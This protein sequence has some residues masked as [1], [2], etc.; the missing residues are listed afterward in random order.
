MKKILLSILGFL[1]ITTINAVEATITFSEKGYANAQEVA[2]V[3]VD[4]NVTLTFDK[5]TNSNTPKYYNTGA[6]LRIYGGGTMT[7]SGV[8]AVIN[9]V[10]MTTGTGNT[11][12]A[13]STVSAGTLE[14]NG[15]TATI[16][17]VNNPEVVFT[18]GGTNGHVRIVTLAVEYTLADAN[19][20]YPPT[21][22]PKGGEYVEGDV[23]QVTITAST[24]N[25]IYYALNSNNLNENGEE[26][27]GEVIEI[28]SNTTVYA[29]ASNG[30]EVSESASATFNFTAPITS[31][32]TFYNLS[33]GNAVKFIRPLTVVYQN[34]SNLIVKDETG[35]MLVYG[36]VGKT[37]NN[38]DVIEA[39]IRGTVGE[40]GGN[41]QLVPTSSTFAAGEPGAA[42]AP[43]VKTVAELKD[44]AFLEYVKL[45]GVYFT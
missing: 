41:K 35:S 15:S 27:T 21:I 30:N 9:K 20:V 10:T 7:V 25:D 18:Q 14:I 24:G 12:N 44:C 6:A 34:G 28:T 8:G 11:V 5:G 22:T 29:W 31:V 36:S 38:G 23:A 26:Y 40:Y 1:C 45:E 3:A 17:E 39:G 33:K 19:A 4:D 32:E 37:Y 2:S 43:T 42:V 16:S 13:E